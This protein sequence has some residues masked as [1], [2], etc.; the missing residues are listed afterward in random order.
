VRWRDRQDIHSRIQTIWSGLPDDSVLDHS[1]TT[2][3]R[4]LVA[5]AIFHQILWLERSPFSTDRSLELIIAESPSLIRRFSAYF[6]RERRGAKWLHPT[7]FPQNP[8]FLDMLWF[9][10]YIKQR[11]GHYYLNLPEPWQQEQW[12]KDLYDNVATVIRDE[13]G[14]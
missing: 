4:L 6:I 12:Y 2:E 5:E 9:L 10:I 3:Q 8:Q 14:S 7:T 13:Q 11:T 1:N